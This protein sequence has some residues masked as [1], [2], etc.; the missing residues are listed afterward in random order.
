MSTTTSTGSIEETRKGS[1]TPVA[2][3]ENSVDVK[4]SEF[5]LV[6]I[7]SYVGVFWLL[8]RVL[9]LLLSKE[10]AMV[11]CG[12]FAFFESIN[13]YR[14]P[15]TFAFLMI[16]L[17]TAACVAS[18]FVHPIS[19]CIFSGL[20][21]FSKALALL[22]NYVVDPKETTLI[23]FL[24]N[25]LAL[26]LVCFNSTEIFTLFTLVLGLQFLAWAKE[27]DVQNTVAMEVL[28]TMLFFYFKGSSSSGLQ[29]REWV[30]QLQSFFKGNLSAGVHPSEWIGQLKNVLHALRTAALLR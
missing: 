17:A 6:T 26:G 3:E 30:Q 8:P 12:S 13:F 25:I 29:L 14:Q 22:K 27:K 1:A 21:G 15:S 5:F 20:I 10:V 23:T 24:L 19:V 18:F 11:S 2:A 7:A 9:P 28:L 4:V 16:A